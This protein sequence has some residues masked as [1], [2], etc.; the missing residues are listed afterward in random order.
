MRYSGI[1][2]QANAVVFSVNARDHII[3]IETEIDA[4]D[5]LHGIPGRNACQA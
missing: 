2:T 4:V 1:P 3:F 5:H